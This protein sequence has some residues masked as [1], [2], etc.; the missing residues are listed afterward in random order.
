MPSG[1]ISRR[2]LRSMRRSCR[3]ERLPHAESAR[4]PSEKGGAPVCGREVHV[5][6][7]EILEAA[8]R[9]DQGADVVAYEAARRVVFLRHV[10]AALAIGAYRRHALEVLKIG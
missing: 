5:I 2:V 8:G 9:I 3:R 7:G 6:E 10:G 1:A 4:D